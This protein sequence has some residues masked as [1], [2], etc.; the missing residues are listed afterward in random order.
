[1]KKESERRIATILFA[2]ISGF[3][4]MSEK[5]DPE[6]VTLLMNEA[7][8]MMG[9][10]IEKNEGRI[11]KY[12]GDCVMVTF[13]VPIAIEDAPHKSINTAI[14]IRNGVEKLNR[15]KGLNPPLGV[16]IGINTGVVLSGMVG[17]DGKQAYTVMGDAV[18][19][20]SRL[21][22][23]S[24]T[25]QVLVGQDTYAA[26]KDVFEYKELQ[27]VSVK[28]K[29]KPIP[30]Y[31]VLSTKPIS[32]RRK[33][34][35]DRM[36]H[37]ELVG[38]DKEL[39][40]LELQIMKAVHGEGSIVNVIG[41][42]GIGKSRLIAELKSRDVM[43]RVTLLEGRAISIGRTLSFYPIIDFL[44]QWS[45]I[46][47]EDGDSAQLR[48]LET[49]VGR[50]HPEEKNEIVPFVGTLMG[51]KLSGQHAERVEGIEGEGLEKLIMKNLRDLLRKASDDQPHV[52][53][54]DDLHWADASSIELLG[55]LF[56][57]AE[58]QKITFINIFRPQYEETS[59][60]IVQSIRKSY[61]EHHVE[62]DL[63]PL[64]ETDCDTLINNLLNIK[65][66]PGQIRGQILER[67]GGNPFFIEEVVRSFIDSG[68]V[69][70]KNGRFEVTS[71]ISGVVVPQTINE[72]LMSRID[73][74]D[75]KTRNLV[76]VAS[77]IG[78]NFFH[79]ILTEVAEASDEL[80]SHLEYLKEIQM[81]R[82]GKRLEEIEYLFKHALAQE[83]AYESILLQK[84]KELHGNVADSIER[85]FNERLHEFYGMLAYHYS[86]AENQ[87]KAEEYMLKAGTEAM[88]AS[89]SNEALK[90]FQNTLD[91]YI[92]KH[93]DLIEPQKF[94]ELEESIA[95]A[96]YNKGRFAESVIYFDKALARSHIVASK[97]QF[98]FIVSAIRTF[99]SILRH[100]YLPS[101]KSKKSPDKNLIRNVNLAVKRGKAG[102]NVDG[103][104]FLTSLFMLYSNRIDIFKY[105]LSES[106]VLL[107]G[108][109]AVSTVFLFSG[110]SHNISRKVMEYIRKSLK[111]SSKTQIPNLK[112]FDTI[113]N[114]MIGD[115]N[116]DLDESYIDYC[117]SKGEIQ[118]STSYLNFYCAGCIQRGPDMN[119]KALG[120]LNDIQDS[121]QDVAALFY[122]QYHGTYYLYYKNRI[123]EAYSNICS[124]ITIGEANGYD[125]LL[126]APYWLKAEVEL[127]IN[128]DDSLQETRN[129]AKA[130]AE[131]TDLAAWHKVYLMR[132]ELVCSLKDLKM[133]IET[134]DKTS[135]DK[136]IKYI[137]IVS[138][139]S[140]KLGRK[141]PIAMPYFYRKIGVY[142][143]LLKKHKKSLKYL[144]LARRVSEKI[145]YRVE[146]SRTYFEIG[147]R[148]LEPQSR[149]KQLNGIT[150]DEY[151]EKARAMF[152][153]MDL[154]WDLEQLEKVRSQNL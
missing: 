144:D 46:T 131:N 50:I 143:W 122:Y 62:V 140:L 2:D 125:S 119:V 39:A 28:G 19:T 68:A 49:L 114:H 118:N 110:I 14:E 137:K 53:I 152:E 79:K 102:V 16:H 113:A 10:I 66:L 138:Q 103:K 124:A 71:S 132:I 73:Q 78:R 6:E 115:Y 101:Y 72:V 135:F 31:E 1:M 126:M 136:N 95:T 64:N 92:K 48:K 120:L 37:S 139:R 3:T 86:N 30:V 36:I 82:E 149:Y 18:N 105:N 24:V 61:P 153:E 154:K 13:G 45:G 130:I 35:S 55:F 59:D 128:D 142:Y 84:R 40:R 97:N 80:E 116:T 96:L 42:G 34:G 85:I 54:L 106:N 150:A 20:A 133:S 146:L 147:K 93:G 94:A 74:L 58:S 100:L 134:D 12:I 69:E 25:G 70:F 109:A 29:E 107:E 4:A 76:K 8:N 22:D 51:L 108:A 38:R 52:I 27:P 26:T 15:A 32:K 98:W 148:L 111:N 21:E 104:I 83:T 123:S 7:F 23:V 60:I 75:E 127:A 57:L 44:K 77:V 91:L 56:R 9:K 67:A 88:G 43:Q 33:I 112:Y 129:K 90:Y 141:F 47:E 151:L 41:E 63:Q 5:I 89:A 99:A 17:A 121:F 145:N 65:G 11:D 87:D 81:I 117:I